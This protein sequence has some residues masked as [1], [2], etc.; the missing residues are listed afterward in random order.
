MGRTLRKSLKHFLVFWLCFQ[1]VASAQEP[2]N[3]LQ[4]RELTLWIP[5]IEERFQVKFSFADQDLS[6]VALSWDPA[7]NLADFLSAVQGQTGLSVQK[8]SDRYYS[9]SLPETVDI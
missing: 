8:L 1:A 2:G 9:L 6:G 4:T 3:N 7:G 5:E